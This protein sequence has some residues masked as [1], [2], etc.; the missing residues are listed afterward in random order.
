MAER[1]VITEEVKDEYNPD[2]NNLQPV[3]MDLGPMMMTIS[4]LTGLAS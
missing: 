1:T 2:L 3:Y 4:P